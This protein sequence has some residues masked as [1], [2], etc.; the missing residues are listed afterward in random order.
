M[1]LEKLKESSVSGNSTELL[2]TVCNK[3]PDCFTMQEVH[4]NRDSLWRLCGFGAQAVNKYLDDQTVNSFLCVFLY[5]TSSV[6][7]V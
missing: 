6:S 5:E 4:F 1:A 7:K 2:L 3:T